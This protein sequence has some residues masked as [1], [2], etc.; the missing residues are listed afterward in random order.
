MRMRVAELGG[1]LDIQQANGLRIT[2]AVPWPPSGG[3]SPGMDHE[4]H[5]NA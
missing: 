3:A 2:V 5:S 4:P 1:S